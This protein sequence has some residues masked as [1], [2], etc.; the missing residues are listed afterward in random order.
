MYRVKMALSI[1]LRKLIIQYHKNGKSLREIGKIV[2]RSFSTIRNIVNKYDLHHRIEDFPR[3]GRPKKLSHRQINSIHRQIKVDPQFSAVQIAKQLSNESETS[4]SASTV[5]RAL[6]SR[7]MH[8]RTPRKK[9]Y[10]SKV[11]KGKRMKFAEN[12]LGYTQNDW[13]RCIF[14]DESKFEVFG[15]KRKQKIWRSLNEEMNP[16]NLIPTVKH[17]GGNVMVW[18]CMAASGV[19]KLV[20]IESTMR[21]E[22]YL[23]ILES[24]L[25][26]SVEKLGLDNDWIFQQDNDPKHTAKIVKR[27]LDENTPNQLFSPPQSPDLNPI[28]HLWEHLDRE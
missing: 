16:K 17:G 2:N 26:P 19:G 18:G 20:F 14:T 8:G 13:N 7:G 5:R 28:E 4:V 12:H 9:P 22:E 1:D 6:H 3:S 15:G 10:I 25:L 11:N 23:D 24:N 21:K 27:W